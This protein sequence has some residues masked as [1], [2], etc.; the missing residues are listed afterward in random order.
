MLFKS[1]YAAHY[2]SPQESEIERA[3]RRKQEGGS[4]NSSL[5]VAIGFRYR[6]LAG[7][8]AGDMKMTFRGDGRRHT[9]GLG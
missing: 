6:E 7:R 4:K 2:P 5:V 1:G 9:A 3:K 8:D